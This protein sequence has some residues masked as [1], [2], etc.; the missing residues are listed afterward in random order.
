MKEREIFSHLRVFP[1][2]AVRIDGRGFSRAL[3]L[4]GLE[5]PYD[6]GFA[7]AMADSIGLFFK[8]SGL[9][10]L[11]AFTF[12]DEISLF[13]NEMSYNNR[14]EKID[15]IIPGFISSAL[16]IQLKL[17]K[18]VSFD[19]RVI[20]LGKEDIYTYLLWRQAETW[21][22]HVS[23]YGFYTLLESGLNENEAALSLKNMKAAEI[24]ELVFKYGINLA[25]TPAWQ[26]CGIMVYRE[27]YEK[28]GYDPIK[29]M[30]VTTKRT[31][32]IQDWNLPIFK[33]EEGKKIIAK[34]VS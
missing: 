3:R 16:T 19:S 25:E 31:K 1:P 29:R 4:L 32:I 6:E 23:S 26:R 34:L 18:P 24:H 14:V 2:F 7:H 22:N 8:E 5:K 21:R 13:F 33:T 20:L 17:E 28:T 15:S 30:E 10:P 9:N 11:F 27:P 12:S